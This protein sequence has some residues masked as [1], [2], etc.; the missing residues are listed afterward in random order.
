METSKR[1]NGLSLFATSE[2]QTL[3]FLLGFDVMEQ[4]QL[5]R[6]CGLEGK[7]YRF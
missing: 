1:E 7:G 5:V 2:P 3:M 6:S 4:Q